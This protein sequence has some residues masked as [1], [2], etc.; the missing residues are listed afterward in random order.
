MALND[1]GNTKAPAQ[2][3]VARYRVKPGARVRLDEWE[4][5]TTGDFD[6][7]KKEGKDLLSNLTKQ[8]A[9]YQEVFYAQGKHRLLI[10]L[11]AMD[12][13][14]KDGTISHVF[15]KVNPQGVKVANFKTPTPQELAHDYLWRIHPHVPGNG[16]MMIFNRSHYEDV[17]IVRVHGLVPKA[18]WERRYEQINAFEKMLADEGTTIVKFCLYISKDEQKERLQARLDD[19]TKHW[20]FDVNDLAERKRWDAYMDAY[21]EMLGRTSTSYAPWFIV[22]GD[23]KWYRNLVVAQTLVQTLEGLDLHYP[24]PEQPLDGIVVE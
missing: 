21:E 1:A 24:E 12:T 22:P 23:R 3:D 9:K 15:K 17:L 11:Q 8:L 5:D 6:G 18:V 2:I 16:E 4:T 7:G 13:G 10:V 19:P 20:K 14:G